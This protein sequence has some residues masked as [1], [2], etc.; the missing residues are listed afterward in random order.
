MV[1]LSLVTISS[2][3]D[4][5]LLPVPVLSP[6]PLLPV[7]RRSRALSYAEPPQS[8]LRVGYTIPN[9]PCT[10]NRKTLATLNTPPPNASIIS[11]LK[12][13]GSTTE[14]PGP[15]RRFIAQPVSL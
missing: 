7:Q 9:E 13:K 15:R 1:C 12:I 2:L 3:P 5:T 8:A 6:S 10:P 14:P 11:K 4:L